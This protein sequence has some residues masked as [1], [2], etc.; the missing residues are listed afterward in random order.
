MEYILLHFHHLYL[1]WYLLRRTQCGAMPH[2]PIQ[3][4]LPVP[5]WPKM[6]V[7]IF[8]WLLF[9]DILHKWLL[10]LCWLIHIQPKERPPMHNFS[11]IPICKIVENMSLSHLPNAHGWDRRPSTVIRY[12][13]KHSIYVYTTHIFAMNNFFGY[14]SRKSQN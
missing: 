10:L 4:L 6:N 3:S 12:L 13:V 5:H 11:L 1:H 2:Y 9:V 14:I 7:N 8:Q